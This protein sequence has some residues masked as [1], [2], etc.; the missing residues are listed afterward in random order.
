MLS[1][2]RIRNNNHVGLFLHINSDIT[3][4]W[5]VVTVVISETVQSVFLKIPKLSVPDHRPGPAWLPLLLRNHCNY[6]YKLAKVIET[7]L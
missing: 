7:A 6:E 3:L 5:F 4:D 1:L 2:T